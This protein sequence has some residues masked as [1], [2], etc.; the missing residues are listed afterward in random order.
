MISR[1]IISPEDWEKLLPI[2]DKEILTILTCDPVP[3]YENRMLV[4]FERVVDK[5]LLIAESSK[6]TNPTI[7]ITKIT[8]NQEASSISNRKYILFAICILLMLI[9]IYLVFKLF[10]TNKKK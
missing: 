5:D 7:D 4:N 10:K 6:E 8:N 1:E 3:T 9:L 2:K